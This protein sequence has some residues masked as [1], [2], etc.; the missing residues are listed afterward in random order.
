[1]SVIYAA[2]SDGTGQGL[3][4]RPLP[5]ALIVEADARRRAGI[6]SC[7]P[8]AESSAPGRLYVREMTEADP[9]YHASEERMPQRGISREDIDA[10]FANP[11]KQEPAA[12]GA[13]KTKGTVRGRVLVVIWARSRKSKDIRRIITVYW[14]DEGSS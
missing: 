6:D 3:E 10:V 4:T 13:F 2:D 12:G 9:S 7:V 1:M 5:P 8:G 11:K 14:E